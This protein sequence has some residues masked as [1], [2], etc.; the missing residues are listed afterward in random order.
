MPKQEPKPIAAPATPTEVST[1]SLIQSH[2]ADLHRT[3]RVLQE[4]SV[5]AA[6]Q[7]FILEHVL[8]DMGI[9]PPPSTGVPIVPTQEETQGQE[10]THPPASET[11]EGDGANLIL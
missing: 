10:A 6:N 2:L 4:Q 7:I 8:K 1:L 3:Q 9:T 5:G 11:A